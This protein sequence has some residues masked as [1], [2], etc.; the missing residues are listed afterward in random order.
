MARTVRALTFPLLTLLLL[1]WLA[2]CA[3]YV[4][5]QAFEEAEA[6]EAEGN[7]A[8]AVGKYFQA[9]ELVPDN[10]LYKLKLLATRTR[11][12]GHHVQKARELAKQGE[13]DAALDHY[14]R[15]R[16]F[17]PS[18]EIAAQEEKVL[19][20][21][22]QAEV[23]AAEAAEFYDS[24]RLSLARKAI[25][26][27]L[28]LDPHNPRALAL[29]DLLDKGRATLAMDG[30][31]LDL[32]SSEPITLRFKDANIKEV[33]GILSKLTGINFIFDADIREQGVSVLLE[34][35]SLAE[36]LELLL[37]MN[38]LGKKVLNS[39]TIIIYPQTKEKEKQYEDQIIQTFY[40]SH[41]D[42]KK[43]VNL[44]RTMLQLRKI[45]V[46]EERN[47][48]VIRDTPQVIRLAEQ[49][50]DA[51]DRANS[52]VLYS[53][54]IIAVQNTDDFRFGPKLSTY[55]V[56]VGFSDGGGKI[57][58]DSLKPGSSV[59]ATNE[60]ETGDSVDGAIQS[61][62]GLQTFYTL[63]TATFDLAKTLT[64]TEVLASPKIRVRNKEKAKVHIG[65]REP[66]ITVTTTND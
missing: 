36:A 44:L 27:A 57:A 42:S 28:Q 58:A 29:Q 23:H 45:Y 6:F 64:N 19:L 14:R 61:L 9:A 39:K 55:G 59:N 20:D 24:R 60:T 8:M 26:Q 32:S 62:N 52:E 2:G 30:F 47:A 11:A 4:G 25:G 22:R 40:L 16:G 66:V 37:Q 38:G 1:V 13:V 15:A 7:Y 63:P 17:D 3:A 51:A 49:V 21:R 46:H 48:L 50:L 33:F 53:L 34:K 41:I 31:E 54:E 56:S 65:T 43:A 18:I 10:R 35:A 5:R 12:A